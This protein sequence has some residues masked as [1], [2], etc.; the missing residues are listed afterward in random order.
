MR[1]KHTQVSIKWKE[2][3]HLRPAAQLVKRAL[4]F[5]SSIL[6]KVKERTADATSILAI[7]MLAATMGSTIEIEA[8]G[9]DE[10]EAVAAITS[11]LEGEQ[12]E[13]PADPSMIHSHG[14]SKP[15]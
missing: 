8:R 4:A 5:E 12:D 14:E 6:L 11:V 7:L 2:G 10:N 1:M 13:V 3:L 15:G 9:I